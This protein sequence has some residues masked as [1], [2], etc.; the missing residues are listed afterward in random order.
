[1]TKLTPWS[2]DLLENITVA[3]L[4]KEFPAF[5]GTKM[6]TEASQ[7]FLSWTRWIQS[8]PSNYFLR[9]FL[10]ISHHLTLRL[11]S[12]LFTAGLW[13]TSSM[14]VSSLPC[15]MPWSSYLP[16]F[17]HRDTFVSGW[18]Y[19]LCSSLCNFLQHPV[20]SL[21]VGPNTECPKSRFTESIL[22]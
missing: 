11:S 17:D 18:E 14:H 16:W 5:Y 2:R 8:T 19:K 13:P 21:I 7:W 6:F 3:E 20:T 1:V 9:S 4:V 12:G 22:V 10:I 15:Y